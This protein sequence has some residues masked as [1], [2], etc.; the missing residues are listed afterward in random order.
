MK[1]VIGAGGAAA[2]GFWANAGVDSSDTAANPAN[3]RV[4]VDIVFSGGWMS[5]Y[6]ASRPTSQEEHP[7]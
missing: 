4:S 5:I 7:V 2:G 3:V 6:L 1:K